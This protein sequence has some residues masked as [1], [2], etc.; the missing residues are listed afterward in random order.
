MFFS[1]P[2]VAERKWKSEGRYRREQCTPFCAGGLISVRVWARLRFG[3]G[4]K[5]HKEA[6]SKHSLSTQDDAKKVQSDSGLRGATDCHRL[7]D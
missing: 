5:D 4:N 1:S 2:R 7:F 6:N 3:I